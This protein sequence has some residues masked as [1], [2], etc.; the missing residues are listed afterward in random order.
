MKEYQE[1]WKR[2]DAF[3]ALPFAEQVDIARFVLPHDPVLARQ[4][5]DDIKPLFEAFHE[6][7]QAAALLAKLDG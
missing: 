7:E 2:R 4:V 1:F 6:L 3:N 5:R